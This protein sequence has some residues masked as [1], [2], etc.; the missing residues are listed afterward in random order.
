MRTP[1]LV[2]AAALLLAAGLVPA[3]SQTGSGSVRGQVTDPSGRSVPE[4]VSA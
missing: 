2:R 1:E 4:P 3:S